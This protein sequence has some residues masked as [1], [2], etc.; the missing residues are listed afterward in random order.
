MFGQSP[1][2]INLNANYLVSETVAANL[3][4]NTF[5]ERISKVGN[6]EVKA[7]RYEQPFHKLDFVLSYKLNAYNFKFSVQNI[8]GDDVEHIQNGKVVKSYDVGTDVG[9]SLSY[10]F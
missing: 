10:K 4:Y 7:D 3:A 8:L 6:S 9:L 1:Y 2:T 5:G